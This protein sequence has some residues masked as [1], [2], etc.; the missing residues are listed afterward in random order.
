[1]NWLLQKKNLKDR[2]KELSD[3]KSK[4]EDLSKKLEEYKKDLKESTEFLR[5]KKDKEEKD[6][7]DLKEKLDK[8]K[9][10]YEEKIAS[11]KKSIDEDTYTINS[12]KK[13][14]PEIKKELEEGINPVYNVIST[15]SLGQIEHIFNITKRIDS[16]FLLYHF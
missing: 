1:M 4:N 6:L 8:N 13:T 2:E 15:S 3:D 5:D 11:L 10:I 9:L 16:E 7:K 14:I 12:N